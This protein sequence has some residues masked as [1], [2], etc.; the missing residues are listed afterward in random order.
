MEK[1]STVII[2]TFQPGSGCT[3]VSIGNV[4]FACRVVGVHV[5]PR[6]GTI[7]VL[8]H[9]TRLGIGVHGGPGSR[10]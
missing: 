4:L 6:R 7:F 10:A 5:D 8:V 3:I 2:T 1:K 9:A